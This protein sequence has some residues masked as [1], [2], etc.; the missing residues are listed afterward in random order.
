MAPTRRIVFLSLALCLVSVLGGQTSSSSN[1]NSNFLD[2]QVQQ[3]GDGKQAQKHKKQEQQVLQSTLKKQEEH[4]QEHLPKHG[5]SLNGQDSI[6]I[7]PG[8]NQEGS[9]SIKSVVKAVAEVPADSSQLLKEEMHREFQEVRLQRAN[10]QQLEQTL[11]SNVDLLRESSSWQKSASTL[12]GRR[13][14]LMQVQQT[15][16]VVKEMTSILRGTRD[17]AVQEARDMLREADEAASISAKLRKEATAQLKA[18]GME[19]GSASPEATKPHKNV[20]FD[21]A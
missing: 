16:K 20:E 3:H 18:L 6:S 10:I 13:A 8:M 5:R 2:K 17:V 19:V 4:K 7:D 14:A 12:V 1:S 21:E 9:Q 15:E 11:K